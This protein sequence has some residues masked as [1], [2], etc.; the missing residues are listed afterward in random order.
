[1]YI[2]EHIW[3]GEQTSTQHLLSNNF[4]LETNAHARFILSNCR[5]S[6]RAN[7]LYLVMFFNV[8]WKHQ[9]RPLETDFYLF[10]WMI[11]SCGYKSDVGPHMQ[12]AQI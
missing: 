6:Q 7:V 5:V 9:Q 12:G 2:T 10:V 8:L 3:T 4:S 1:M 11:Q